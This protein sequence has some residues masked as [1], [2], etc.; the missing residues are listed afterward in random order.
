MNH[1]LK[2]L[3]Y[4]YRLL[5]KGGIWYAHVAGVSFINDEAM[6]KNRVEEFFQDIERLGFHA[7]FSILNPNNILIKK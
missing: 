6:K 2:F 1:Y 3:S 5:R 7:S 4:S